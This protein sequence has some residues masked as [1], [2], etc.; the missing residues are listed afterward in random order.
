M[1][2]KHKNYY[3]VLEIS[4]NANQREIHKKYMSAKNA[5][6][7]DSLALYSLMS[8]NECEKQLE[9]VEEAYSILSD[10]NKRN[11]Y[12]KI[13][14]I[15]QN[16][17]INRADNIENISNKKTEPPQQKLATLMAYKRF[18]L[19]HEINSEFEQEIEQAT[20]FSGEFLRKIREYKY[21]DIVRMSEM[22]KVSKTYIMNIE[23]ED[24]STLPAL[25]YVRGF[26]Y[27]YAKCLKINPEIVANSYLARLKKIKEGNSKS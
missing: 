16:N 6:T 8:K 1:N 20:E 2:E 26:V 25:V 18:S 15:N 9:E 27:Q 12:D 5:Y 3:E 13:R 14:G 21:V 4:S 23:N 10:S 17:Q 24:L 19:E 7:S 22:T 11:Q